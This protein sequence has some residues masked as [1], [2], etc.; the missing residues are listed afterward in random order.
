[1]KFEGVS[2]TGLCAVGVFLLALTARLVFIGGFV[3]WNTPPRYDAAQYDA[4]AWSVA[5]GGPYIGPDGYY[6]HRAPAYPYLLS[7][8]YRAFGHS[9][10]AARAFQALMGAATSAVVLLLGSRCIAPRVRVLA[11]VVCAVFPY[12]IYWSG[13]LLSE[14]LCI[15]VVALTTYAL[16]ECGR[17]LAWIAIWSCLC[18]IA[19]LT[20]PNMGLL[21]LAG[22]LW[23]ATR[24]RRW[25]ARCAVA[26]AI[27]SLTL[28]PWTLR[29][30]GIHHRIIAVTTMGG[31]VLWESNNP[32]NLTDREMLGRSR[33]APDL[34]ESRLVQGLPEAQED[35]TYFRLGLK[36]IGDHLGEMPVL[37][38]YKMGRLW[39]P[40][41]ILESRTQN[42][43]ASLTIIPTFLFFGIGLLTAWF[44]KES[45][46]IPILTPI[47]VVTLTAA[48]Y[49]GDARIR[50]PAEPFIQILAAYGLL[51][52]LDRARTHF[53][54]TESAPKRA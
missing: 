26:T 36:F 13:Y 9:W 4:I 14:P 42:T 21:F 22:L 53:R 32:Y 33:H 1:M 38:A 30:Y 40:F 7:G 11:S 15:L 34:P 25:L 10:P 28:V 50:S 8:V 54:R 5:R 29:N 23:I 39:N 43:V 35:E 16:L 46:L 2:G 49:W 31:V 27:F 17:S 45:W 6:S 12:S 41:P 3:G 47:V 52:G 48:V 24:D 19:A 44:R 37:V 20:R 18:G 51:S